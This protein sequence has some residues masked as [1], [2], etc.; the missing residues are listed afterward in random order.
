MTHDEDI[1]EDLSD[2]IESVKKSGLLSY[3]KSERYVFGRMYRQKKITQSSKI[4]ISQK[5]DIDRTD[6]LFKDAEVPI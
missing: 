4:L 3:L 6:L 5:N 2:T 1:H